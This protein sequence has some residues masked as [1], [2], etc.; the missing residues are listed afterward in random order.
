MST[1]G[2]IWTSLYILFQVPNNEQIVRSGW[3]CFFAFRSDEAKSI[4]NGRMRGH[5][6]Y[7]Q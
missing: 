4:P 1:R 6:P 7:M 2:I 5:I 3:L